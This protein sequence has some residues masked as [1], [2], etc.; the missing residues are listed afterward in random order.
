MKRSIYI[1][2]AAAF[3]LTV[4]CGKDYLN[5]P[6]QGTLTDENFYQSP[7]AGYKTLVNCYL[8]F[9][10]FWGY[11]AVL[12]ELGN[13]ATDECD[14]GGS[15]AG[16][17][18]F[19]TDLGY[20]RALSSN[21]TLQNFWTACYSAIGNCNV[22][23]EHLP[24]AA[25]I[26]AGGNLVDE[27]TKNRY[28]AEI[29]FLRSFYYFDLVRVFGGVPL[30]TKTLAPED[31]NKLTRASAQDIFKFITDEW[32]A[33]A[34]DPALPSK[35]QLPAA[36]Q[37]RVTQET[38][39]AMLARADLFFAGEDKSLYTKAKD[40]AKKVIDAKAFAL[41]PDYQDLFHVNGY[42]SKEAVF[43][44]IFGDDPGKFII[45][46]TLPQYCSPRSIGGWGFDCPTQSLVDA[47]EP[48]DPRRLFTVLDQGD[49]FP[50]SGGQ[51]VLDFSNYPN[52][53]HHNRKEFLVAARRGQAFGNDAW[54]LHLIRYADVLLMY[55]EAL[56][57]SGGSK[58]EAA[59]YINMVRDRASHSSR[60]DAEATKRVTVIADRTLP[61]VKASDDL[62]AAVRH[63]RRVELGGEYQ[64]LFDLIRWGTYVSTMHDFATRPYSNGKGAAFKK[65]A[66]GRYLFPIP[67]AEIDRSGGSI[68]Q[69]PGY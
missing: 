31:R 9:Y 36:E 44:V 37:G 20:G 51:E 11:Q 12:A 17:R 5:R 7:D 10:N 39:W 27:S 24:D 57:E 26:D 65:P 68:V 45:G 40:A 6:P 61:E 64:R 32:S 19:V 53:G 47:F 63:E 41:E 69:N 60:T 62:R 21:E 34:A 14:K 42:K 15:D 13:M 28:I 46:S 38:V 66:S 52:T 4:S 54:T 33:C 56:V 8:G 2:L 55:A 29:R 58:Q 30:L 59:D 16:D 25:L 1:C 18:P 48:G 35:N 3:L 50:K 23:L 22:A 67:Q 43:P 49:Q